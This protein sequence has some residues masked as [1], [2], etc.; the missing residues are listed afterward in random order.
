M[1]INWDALD[2][3]E[4]SNRWWRKGF[5]DLSDV[6]VPGEGDNPQ[7]FIIGEAPGAQEELR[8]RPFVGPAGMVLRQLM[9]FA[10]FSTEDVYEDGRDSPPTAGANC[11]LTNVVK[12]RP[13]RNRTPTPLE[14]KAA[15]PWLRRE[16]QAVGRPRLI[17]P[18]GA[19][20]LHAVL[21]RKVS[22]LKVSGK[23]QEHVSRSMAPQQLWVYP[24]I[25]P[26]YGLRNE[27]I[28]PL[29]EKDWERL[30]E[31]RENSHNRK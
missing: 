8:R 16:W 9:D 10:G 29:L 30:G 17:I 21:G 19:V 25:H 11:W 20:A 23:P 4:D 7:A 3:L 22:I 28:R 15:R 2:K 18:V 5:P 31:W 13:P 27:A 1:T 26:S 24:M 6:Y 12:F 14:I